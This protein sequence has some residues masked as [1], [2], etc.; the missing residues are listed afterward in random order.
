[1]ATGATAANCSSC[2]NSEGRRTEITSRL[3]EALGSGRYGVRVVCRGTAPETWYDL[4]NRVGG[5]TTGAGNIEGHAMAAQSLLRG[6]RIT[7][8]R[9][10]NNVIDYRA[11]QGRALQ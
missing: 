7:L 4:Q 6:S 3:R 2:D 9:L 8:C 5:S 10:D 1:M 11:D